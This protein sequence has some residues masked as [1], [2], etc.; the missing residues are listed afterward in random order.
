M[1]AIAHRQHW[2]LEYIN[3]VD[4][5]SVRFYRN[6]KAESESRYSAFSAVSRL[7][8]VY[9]VPP[10]LKSMK[11]AYLRDSMIYL[12]QTDTSESERVRFKKTIGS[13]Y[14]YHFR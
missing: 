8:P 10:F 14:D 7:L 4:W 11:K 12:H 5:I 13:L 1:P 2:P 6:K 9:P 3:A